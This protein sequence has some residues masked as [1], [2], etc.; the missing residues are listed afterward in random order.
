MNKVADE[1][2]KNN[3]AQE[4]KADDEDQAILAFSDSLPGND[5]ETK[6]VQVDKKDEAA[7]I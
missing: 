3:K 5:G 6:P 1:M 4:T 7:K 2:E